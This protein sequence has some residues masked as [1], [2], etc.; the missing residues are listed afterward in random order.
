MLVQRQQAHRLLNA[1][2]EDIAKARNE[3]SPNKRR[4]RI[5]QNKFSGPDFSGAD[6]DRADGPQPV[7]KAKSK[8]EIRRISLQQFIHPRKGRFA[9]DRLNC[10]ILS[11]ITSGKEE[12]L[13]SAE[14]SCRC[15][16]G[17]CPIGQEM[18]VGKD[19][20]QKH[21]GLASDSRADEDGQQ[22]ILCHERFER[23]GD[24]LQRTKAQS[25][26]DPKGACIDANLSD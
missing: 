18:P 23:H 17:H 2:A 26:A 9:K 14:R 1:L 25:A 20:S 21:H 16:K 22:P 6:R 10:A 3:R 11:R 24:G 4:H 7:K 13:V 19:T 5:E 15:C 12:Y 8:D